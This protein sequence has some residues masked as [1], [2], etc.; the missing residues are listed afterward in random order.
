MLILRKKKIF[1][2][3]FKFRKKN[4]WYK[5]KKKKIKIIYTQL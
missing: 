1:E 4:I 5:I 2:D 3:G